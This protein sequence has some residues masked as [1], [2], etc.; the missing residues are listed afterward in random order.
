MKKIVCLVAVLFLV[1]CSKKV[2]QGT[3]KS[4]TR[5]SSSTVE[6]SR[7]SSTSTSSTSSATSESSSSALIY[8]TSTVQPIIE[9][10]VPALSEADLLGKVFSG[11]AIFDGGRTAAYTISFNAVKNA[12]LVGDVL[13]TSFPGSQAGTMEYFDRMT[14][15]VTGPTSYRVTAEQP[16]T[17]NATGQPWVTLDIVKTGDNQIE[18]SLADKRFILVY[19]EQMTSQ[20]TGG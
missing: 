19:D 8:E 10:E 4:S 1:G 16:K 9:P 2:E 12:D 7:E 17:E 3:D 11:E 14:V 20:L 13:F 15:S 5:P 6:S 18:F